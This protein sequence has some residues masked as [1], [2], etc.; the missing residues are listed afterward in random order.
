MG[1]LDY[2]KKVYCQNMVNFKFVVKIH[3]QDSVLVNGIE[4]SVTVGLTTGVHGLET[5]QDR[6]RSRSFLLVLI[7][8]ASQVPI[9]VVGGFKQNRRTV[10][11]SGNDL[12]IIGP[13][14]GQVR[15]AR[16]NNGNDTMVA[17]CTWVYNVDSRIVSYNTNRYK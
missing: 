10:M 15:K 4:I 13:D 5:A 8:R 12:S 1:A 16:G 2:V 3:L 7:K 17:V 11:T 9:L 14:Q 6:S